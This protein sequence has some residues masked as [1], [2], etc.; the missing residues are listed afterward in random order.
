MT[1]SPYRV[2]TRL[3]GFEI[4][5]PAYETSQAG[6]LEWLSR[7]HAASARAAST[8]PASF[9]GRAYAA[10]VSKLLARVGCS[11]EKIAARGYEVADISHTRWEDM[12]VY[13]VVRRPDGAPAGTR[14]EVFMRA[15]ERAF[16]RL[17]ATVWTPPSD[18]IHV[19]CTGYASPSAAQR[20]VTRRGWGETTRVTHAYHMGCYAALPAIRMAAGFLASASNASSRADIVH[21][22]ICSLHLHPAE[23]APEQLV[24]QS[25]F[26]DGHVR[27]S[28]VRGGESD[29]KSL[30]LL[31]ARE[32]LVPDSSGAMSWIVSD[33]GMAM[34]LAR[35]VPMR[36]AR[37]VREFVASLYAEGKL[38]M[39]R[40]LERTVFAV[41]PGGP[42]IIEGIQQA[43]ELTDAQTAAS[44]EVLFRF[45]NMSS[46]TL[47]HVWTALMNDAG[48][49]TGTPIVS[50]AFGPGL[51]MCGALMIKE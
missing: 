43:L 33:T 31:S 30:T 49:T 34:T 41:H 11:P 38:D 51:T 22:E 47:P 37:G 14:T 39:R 46:S 8:D 32:V 28:V 26:A 4:V 7:L 48:V 21:T 3:S 5:R 23:H 17:Y 1:H 16:E 10:Q 40:D 50:L 36:I 18:L 42:R 19:T 13:D 2:A 15:A 29:G 44:R 35:D 45:G 24:V 12:L 27:Y 9:D 6:S 25:L 20:L